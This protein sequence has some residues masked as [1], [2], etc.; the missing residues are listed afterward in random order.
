MD[1]TYENIHL[2]NFINLL[3]ALPLSSA[4]GRFFN[5]LG[6]KISCRRKKEEKY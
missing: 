3:S 5:K 2:R 6:R 1:F 4:E